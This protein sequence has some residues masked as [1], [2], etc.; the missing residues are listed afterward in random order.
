[1]EI[2][3][4]NHKFDDKD[5]ERLLNYVEAFEEFFD[6]HPG[7]ATNFPR[8]WRIDVVVD[9]ENIKQPNNKRAFKQVKD[10]DHVV[11]KSWYDFLDKAKKVH[12]Q[13][14]NVHDEH[15]KSR[16]SPAIRLVGG[17]KK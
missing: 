16:S 7:L 13:F 1:V 9:G 17:G 2:K 4:A 8:G 14:L 15:L 11:L 3:K 12:E 5:L 10:S 6:A